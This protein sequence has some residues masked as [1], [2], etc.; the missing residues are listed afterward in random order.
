VGST[1]LAS[2]YIVADLPPFL[3]MGFRL[4][5]AGSVLLLVVLATRGRRA[6]RATPGRPATAAVCGLGLVASAD[7]AVVIGAIA[8]V[9][10]A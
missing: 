7:R 2:T 1:D 3:A 6:L 10:T 4:L 9:L 8:L 5:A